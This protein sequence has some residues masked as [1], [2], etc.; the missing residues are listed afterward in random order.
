MLGKSLTCEPVPGN[1]KA[2]IINHSF[3]NT[4]YVSYRNSQY[5][6][7]DSLKELLTTI[8]PHINQDYLRRYFKFGE[9]VNHYT[10]WKDLYLSLPGSTLTL[11]E[12]GVTCSYEPWNRGNGRYHRRKIM[13]PVTALQ[14]AIP[15]KN[16]SMVLEFSGGTDSTSL[17]YVLA[18]QGSVNAITWADPSI[19]HASDVKN[20]TRIAEVLNL[21]HEISYINPAKIFSIPPYD[22]YP[23]RPSISI[24]MMAEKDRIIREKCYAGEYVIVNGHGGDHIFLDPPSPVALIDLIISGKIRDC[25]GYYQKLVNFYREGLLSPLKYRSIG[26]GIG[27]AKLRFYPG[28]YLHR[29]MIQQA[30]YENSLWNN[31]GLPYKVIHP[32]TH[33]AMLKYAMSFEP[34]E[35]VGEGFSRYP[36][37][38]AM[39]SYYGSDDFYRVSKGHLTGVFQQAVNIQYSILEHLIQAGMGNRYGLYDTKALL[40]QLSSA[41]V[42]SENIDPML[43]NALSIEL[44]FLHWKNLTSD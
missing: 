16:Q 44:F 1:D 9:T 10:A 19:P 27:D 34:H 28:R 30:C 8:K 18:G 43:I 33:P 11:N 13:H 37:R 36:F 24:F 25:F 26:R 21:Q 3:D 38:K 7:W 31:C 6:I 40:N 5:I 32:F 23:D 14:D 4:L 35:L 2:K 29:R 17:A 39:S 41:A 12:N 20:A 42:G 22:Y 15:P